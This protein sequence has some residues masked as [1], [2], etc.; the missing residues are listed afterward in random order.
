MNFGQSILKHTEKKYTDMLSRVTPSPYTKSESVDSS[1]PYSSKRD[2]YYNRLARE[3]RE[4]NG[5]LDTILDT[6]DARLRE[7]RNL[8]ERKRRDR[9]RARKVNLPFILSIILSLAVTFVV[10]PLE[11]YAWVAETLIPSA[12]LANFFNTG[13]NGEGILA[14][15][16]TLALFL[17]SLLTAIII[18]IKKEGFLAFLGFIWTSF[19]VLLFLGSI[20]LG[21]LFCVFRFLVFL[22]SYVSFA[23]V[24]SVAPLAL[25]VASITLMIIYGRGMEL[26]RNKAKT[27]I[28]IVAGV[29]IAVVLFGLADSAMPYYYS[30]F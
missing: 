21:I 2:A 1:N 15:Q 5:A 7:E 29:L 9:R 27:A 8:K 28:K 11:A 3:R 10:V 13:P 30:I 25:G 24:S 22:I 26:K 17:I 19:L 20:I 18:M 16:L 12:S 6:E 14:L 4:F 23:L